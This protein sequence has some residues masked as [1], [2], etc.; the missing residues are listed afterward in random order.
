MGT[1]TEHKS[2]GEMG[3]TPK[4]PALSPVHCVATL[5]LGDYG[6]TLLLPTITL[7]YSGP[8]FP[9]VVMGSL[10]HGRPWL[11]YTTVGSSR[12]RRQHIWKHFFISI[13]DTPA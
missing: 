1:T 11:F 5:S 13:D 10:R 2:K 12:A 4:V 8:M 6:P 9:R 3:S 7:A